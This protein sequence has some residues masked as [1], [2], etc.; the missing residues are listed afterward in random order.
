MPCDD[1]EITRP[2]RTQ[3]TL[4][5]LKIRLSVW[6]LA[7]LL[8]G[9]CRTPTPPTLPDDGPYALLLGSAQDAGLPQI[10]CLQACCEAARSDPTRRRLTSALLI[11]DPDSGGR[12]LLDAGPD[13]REQVERMRTHPLSRDQHLATMERRA[14]PDTSSIGPAERPPL[15][16]AIF[17][18]HAHMGHVAGLLHLG[19]EAYAA[20]EMPVYGTRSMVR[21]LRG[22]EPWASMVAAGHL[23]PMILKPGVPVALRG[24]DG[25]T[26]A[27]LS[28]TAFTVPHRDE[29]TDTVGFLVRGPRAALVYLPDIDKW[30]RWERP[31]EDLLADVDIALLDGTF[32]ADGELPGR[33]MASIPH[34]FII[35]SVARLSAQPAAVR[36]PVHFTHLNHGNPAAD[37]HS[38]AA[39]TVHRAG[40]HVARDGDIFTL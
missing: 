20:R 14:H 4:H 3:S 33:D 18:T 15:V 17:L 40:M 19:R 9:A 26:A 13:L 39:K 11:V 28:I 21:F 34:P 27:G 32:F 5:R 7:L 8:S 29:V 37:P 6:S 2:L 38:E 22:H 36:A 31:V 23:D 35:E 1:L 25:V 10:G 12:W 24:P 30:S 16:D